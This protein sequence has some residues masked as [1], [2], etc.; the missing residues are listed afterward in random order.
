[1]MEARQKPYDFLEYTTSLCSECL[2]T[3]PGKI[4][5]RDGRI[6]IRK[7][8]A[9][10]GP[11]EELLE[12]NAEYFIHRNEFS[13][14]GSSCDV[15]TATVNGCPYDCGLCPNHEQHTCIGLIEVNTGCD[16]CC[17]TC[18]A[19][20]GKPGDL[21]LPT[22]QRMIDFYITSENG[23]AEILQVSGGEPTLHPRILEILDYARSTKLA[24]VMLNTNGLRIASDEPFVRELARMVGNF[25]VYLQ[26]DGLDARVSESLRGRNYIPDKLRAVGMLAK[27]NI[28]TTLVMTVQAGTND[29]QIGD[30]VAFAMRHGNIRGVSFQPMAFFGRRPLASPPHDRATLTG[31]LQRIEEQTAGLVKV[32]DFA[33]L[34]CAVDRVA[35]TFLYRQQ[36]DY[37]PVTRGMDLRQYLPYIRN[38]FAFRAEEFIAA[39]DAA[40]SCCGFLG[41]F[42]RSFT[43]K[44]TA[45]RVQYINDNLFRLSV[46][47]FIDAYNFDM[48]AM[49][50]E[51]VHVITPDL[52]KIPFSA[53]NLLHR[54]K[55]VSHYLSTH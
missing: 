4:V 25:E 49:Q 46:V 35:V 21:S 29:E 36:G 48:K 28:P 54:S 22:I 24:Y 2:R 55:Y 19:E 52:H 38:T 20:S 39:T 44:S 37:V 26:F 27:H 51:C 32:S 50:K 9:T 15:Q 18:Y 53:Y 14:P 10:H 41:K 23:H 30:V 3:V 8:C 11:Q 47:S 17:P 34:P 16:M 42:V 45:E 43:L 40:A 33:P 5:A 31:V 12:D 6:H 7:H 13:R 1:M